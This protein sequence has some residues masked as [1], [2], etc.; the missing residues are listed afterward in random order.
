MEP[1]GQAPLRA[2][3][4]NSKGKPINPFTGKPVQLPAGLTKAERLK[5]IR[6]RTHVELRP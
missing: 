5:Y 4:T 3:F 2:S 1:S 6:D